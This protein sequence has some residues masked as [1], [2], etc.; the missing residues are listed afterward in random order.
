MQ[1]LEVSDAANNDKTWNVFA[2]EDPTAI[3]LLA[4]TGSDLGATDRIFTYSRADAEVPGCVGLTERKVLQSAVE[5]TSSNAPVLL[6]MRSLQNDGWTSA[7]RT[8]RH[9][10]DCVA[11]V[12]DSREPA[13]KRR[14]YQCLRCLPQLFADG[15][16]PFSSTQ[17]RK[18]TDLKRTLALSR[19]R[20]PDRLDVECAS[21]NGRVTLTS[22]YRPTQ[23]AT[24]P[25]QPIPPC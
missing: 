16:R 19:C 24:K 13:I 17:A 15:A 12:F 25:F 7:R 23:P 6:L 1:Y 21:P 3:D 9:T 22:L 18:R 2:L 11:K 5:L 4:I 8:V 14:Y 10:A 20:P